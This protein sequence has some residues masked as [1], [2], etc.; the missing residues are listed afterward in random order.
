MRFSHCLG[1]SLAAHV[2]FVLLVPLPRHSAQASN[3]AEA[4]TVRVLDEAPILQE[5][6][7]EDMPDTPIFAPS[8]VA[9]EI[10]EGMGAIAPIPHPREPG[11][12]GLTAGPILPE[13]T[14]TG[15][16]SP[17]DQPAPA[18]PDPAASQY[19]APTATG[20][21]QSAS[22][23]P[24]DTAGADET[25]FVS[26]SSSPGPSDPAIAA[27][28]PGDVGVGAG[29]GGT[30]DSGAGPAA[31]P[32]GPSPAPEGPG[33]GTSAAGTGTRGPGTGDSGSGH[34]GSGGGSDQGGGRP[35][36]PP[37]QPRLVAVATPP[38]PPTREMA[39]LEVHGSVTLTI[40]IGAS[41]AVTSASVVRGSGYP[42]YD[43][44]A[45]SWVRDNW[46]YKWEGGPGTTTTKTVQLRF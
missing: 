4:I 21:D 34:S 25:R 23:V 28:P 22:E 39:R 3:D 31:P 6:A 24:S 14:P 15:G 46:R 36:P 18:A 19:I 44:Q 43:S 27:A 38:C 33:T 41:G 7:P 11:K 32:G 17:T 16:T 40:T 2:V 9:L 13:D 8:R 45:A 42:Q 26:G 35:S 12:P 1:L 5:P 29:P 30:S 20:A 37:K 10:R